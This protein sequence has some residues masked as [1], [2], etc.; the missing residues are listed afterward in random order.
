MEDFFR[1]PAQT[2]FSLSPD[3]ERIAFLKPWKNR[4]NLYVRE[5][6][7]KEAF[8]VTDE[9]ERGVQAYVWANNH[10]LAYINDQG[11]DENWQ[12]HAVNID[13]SN[14]T[15]MELK[16]VR[17]YLIDKLKNNDDEILIGANKRDPKV[18]DAYRI[19]INTG[20]LSLAAENPG[21][22]TRWITDNQGRLRVA[23]ASDNL[24]T[25]LLS[26]E[27]ESEPF[28]PFMT[29][30][31]RS[32]MIPLFFTFDDQLLYVSSNIGRDKR[33]IYTVDPKTGRYQ[34]LIYAHPEVDVGH[35]TRSRSRKIITG[36]YFTTHRSTGYFWDK[37][38]KRLQE[39]LEQRLPGYMVELVGSSKDGRKLLIRT[40]SDKSMGA[41]Y[42]FDMDTRVFKKLA[43][44]SPWIDE[45]Q[46]ADMQPIRYTA[47]DGLT[48][49][50]YLTIPK[51][52]APK[53]LP[54]VV[55]P[56]G[57]PWNRNRW[58]FNPEVQFLAN[59]GLAVLQI[60]FRGST[61]YGKAF[62]E[63]GFKQWGKKMQDDI[64]DGVQ[65]LIER[66]VADPDRIGIYGISFGG[67]AALAG[68]AFTPDLYACGVDYVGVS[69][70]FTFLNTIPPYWEPSRP[71]WMQMIG[72]PVKDKDLLTEASPFFH[73][74][75]IK[76]PLFVA[77][78]A[79]D[80]RVK[81][82]ESDQIVKALKER[83]VEVEYMVKPDEGHGFR[84]EENR[85]DFYRAM[86]R[87]LARHLGSRAEGN[88]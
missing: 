38:R 29:T 6:R 33:A 47:R 85:F 16:N 27:T 88:N 8:R 31:F 79:N 2:R 9:T 59:R 62:W 82:A 12:G 76:A 35:L 71:K 7:G 77:H 67:Y 63:A 19:N 23:V 36:V 1:N 3:G 61:G 87:F 58:G 49:Q 10:R 28:K 81:R 15:H 41:W 20:E 73:A 40:Y 60:N 65:W 43:D 26:R 55:N 57:G 13:R 83:G 48:I 39:K 37:K 68:L 32:A 56:H 44:I 66:G 69:N 30:D 34:E 50:G 78:G 54:L 86:E 18:F 52:A 4:L 5:V 51:G 11:G 17:V 53:N 25:T 21:N 80:P 46:M 75:R 22:I 70:I 24:N 64:T 72:D 74:D 42:F 84:N 45:T 14:P